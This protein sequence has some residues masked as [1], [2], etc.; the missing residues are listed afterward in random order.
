MNVEL[1]LT[2]VCG[3]ISEFLIS[4]LIIRPE[5][6]TKED[7]DKLNFLLPDDGWEAWCRLWHFFCM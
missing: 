2:Y 6:K 5:T 7:Q 1:H 3:I 4:F